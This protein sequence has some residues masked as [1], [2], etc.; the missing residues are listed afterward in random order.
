MGDP[1]RDAGLH[2]ANGIILEEC[3]CDH[4]VDRMEVGAEG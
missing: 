1:C 3:D 2:E 4:T